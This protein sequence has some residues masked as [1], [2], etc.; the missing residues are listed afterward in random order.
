MNYAGGRFLTSTCYA[1][2]DARYLFFY[3]S[4]ER[5][6]AHRTT[7]YTSESLCTTIYSTSSIPLLHG[8]NQTMWWIARN[9]SKLPSCEMATLSG[10]R[11]EAAKSSTWTELSLESQGV[12]IPT[13]ARLCRPKINHMSRHQLLYLLLQGV[14]AMLIAGVINFIF[15]YLDYVEPYTGTFPPFIFGSSALFGDLAITT[16]L[17]GIATWMCALVL[18]NWDLCRGRVAPLH[19]TCELRSSFLRWFM[20]LDHYNSERGSYLCGCCDRG[21]ARKVMFVLAN[22]GRGVLVAM[23]TILLTV[24]PAVG[25]L[26]FAGKEYQRRQVFQGRWD[27]PVFKMVY[28]GLLAGLTS[29]LLAYM[30]MV[31]TGWI[32]GEWD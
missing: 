5:R 26:V 30:W 20:F 3:S 10:P 2:L 21:M 19:Y 27:G 15:G 12:E 6:V 25:L 11:D 24:G 16:L 4:A 32:T 9:P 1:F 7:R 23:F 14:S 29:P 13:P 31:R 18:V 8:L 22:V 28:G 17:T